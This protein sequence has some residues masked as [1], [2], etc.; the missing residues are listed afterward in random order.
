MTPSKVIATG[1]V[2]LMATCGG[3]LA[4]VPEGR[5][6]VFHSTAQGG[7]PALDWHV[8]AGANGTLSGMISWNNMES[9]AKA[10][11][12]ARSGKVQMTATEVGGQNRTATVT[13]T[14][15]PDGWLTVNVTG[16][17]VSCQNINIPFFSAP[18]GGGRG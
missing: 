8:T 18:P 16:P 10:T 5:L 6:F 2:A 15:R 14:I 13:G 17:N 4:Q 12:T 3:A 11:G 1:A 9:M 7:C